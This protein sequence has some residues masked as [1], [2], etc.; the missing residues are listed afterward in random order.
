MLGREI[1]QESI[2]NLFMVGFVQKKYKKFFSGKNFEAALKNATRYKN[3]FSGKHFEA[4]V[5]K[6]KEKFF[7]KKYKKFFK[8]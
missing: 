8:G 5:A 2:K 3:F 7:L 6:N 4:G 1:F